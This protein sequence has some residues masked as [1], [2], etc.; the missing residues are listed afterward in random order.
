[1]TIIIF[2]SYVLILLLLSFFILYAEN[3]KTRKDRVPQQGDSDETVS[4]GPLLDSIVERVSHDL[5]YCL[6]FGLPNV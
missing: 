6:M 2:S 3:M 4:S 1:M 5:Q